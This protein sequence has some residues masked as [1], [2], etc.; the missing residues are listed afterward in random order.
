MTS[1]IQTPPATRPAPSLRDRVITDDETIRDD[2]RIESLGAHLAVVAAGG[3][4][5]E[6]YYCWSFID[7]FEW[8]LEYTT[9][10]PGVRGPLDANTDPEE[11]GVVLQPPHR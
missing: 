11:Q 1:S 8:D 6:D 10:W 7:R 3:I 2:D 9:R 4:Q 5:I